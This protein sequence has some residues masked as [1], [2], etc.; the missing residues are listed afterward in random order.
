MYS[1]LL[2]LLGDGDLAVQVRAPPP[3]GCQER[4]L[5]EVENVVSYYALD[6]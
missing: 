3:V 4:W 2:S 1:A 5:K 6:A